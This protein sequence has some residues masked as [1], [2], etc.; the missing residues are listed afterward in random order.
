MS[1]VELAPGAEE[2]GLAAMLRDLV[3]QNIEAKPHKKKGFDRIKG[4]VAI[5][6]E[7]ADVALTLRFRGGHLTIHDGIVGIP[8]VAIRASSD[9]ILAMSTMPV[10]T[11]LALPIPR[12]GDAEG[13]ATA[14]TVM[15]AMTAGE[16]QVLGGLL[17]LPLMLR[18][19]R[20]M[21]VHG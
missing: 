3:Q 8:D 5:V 20:V 2:N 10:S 1:F 13:M 17:H 9:V 7:D 14:R 16:L 4:S 19:T 11:K 6:A 18:L 15:Q 12:P 21:S